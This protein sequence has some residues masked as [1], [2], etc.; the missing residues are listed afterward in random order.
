MKLGT[1]MYVTFE[2]NEHVFYSVRNK[3][4]G[5]HWHHA[6]QHLFLATCGQYLYRILLPIFTNKC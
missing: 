2:I 5:M 3:Y 4:T 1:S 6:L